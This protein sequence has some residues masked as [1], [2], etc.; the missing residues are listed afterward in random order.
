MFSFFKHKSNIVG[1]IC[2]NTSKAG[3]LKSDKFTFI[4][5]NP[6]NNKCA[7]LSLTGKN[8]AFKFENKQAASN[9]KDTE[10]NKFVRLYSKDK[11][12]IIPPC[13][14]V[15]KLSNFEKKM[16][17]KLNFTDT[18][19]KLT[20]INK[21]DR[22][23]NLAYVSNYKTENKYIDLN[24]LGYHFEN[25]NLSIIKHHKKSVPIPLERLKLYSGLI[26]DRNKKLIGIRPVTL[27]NNRDNSKRVDKLTKKAFPV[28]TLSGAEVEKIRQKKHQ[29]KKLTPFDTSYDVATQ[30]TYQG[31]DFERVTKDFLKRMFTKVS[32]EKK[33]ILN[34]K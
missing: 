27:L 16:I 21:I 5:F 24:I 28:N 22:K 23:K 31:E 33:L 7:L 17:K 29:T 11:V 20:T 30:A 18:K 6:N 12:A 3:F 13:G 2:N 9:K 32:I 4:R 25:G 1:N 10:K 19:I 14:D 26:K 8:F 34:D 15:K